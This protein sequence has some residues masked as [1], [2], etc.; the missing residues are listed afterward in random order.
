MQNDATSGR[1]E[2]NYPLQ[3]GDLLLRTG[4]PKVNHF[5][6]H[7]KRVA[8]IR[9]ADYQNFDVMPIPC[10]TVDEQMPCPQ[11]TVDMSGC[12]SRTGHPAGVAKTAHAHFRRC[13]V[14]PSC[15][16]VNLGVSCQQDTNAGIRQAPVLGRKQ[17]NM[18]LKHTIH[19]ILETPR[20]HLG[21]LS[22][23]NM[24]EIL[25]L[26][27]RSLSPISFFIKTVTP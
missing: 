1:N 2:R 17:E 19:G 9:Q 4:T 5:Q 26:A 27:W 14:D 22:V 15:D 10:R 20:T 3:Q 23:L 7:R 8:M 12:A 25:S 6:R 16:L 24:V 13:A 11:E 18:T 21:S